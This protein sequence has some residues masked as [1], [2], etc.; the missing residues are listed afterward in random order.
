[1]K[2]NPN[3]LPIKYLLNV[4]QEIPGYPTHDDLCYA[5][6]S[7]LDENGRLSK[8]FLPEQV[9]NGMKYHVGSMTEL[10][11]FLD[12]L[13]KPNTDTFIK[14]EKNKNRYKIIY[15]PWT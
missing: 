14:I 7:T 1:M 6:V 12:N 3:K 9:W 5:L 8:E 15:T 2:I 11:D 4:Y 10:T 13:S